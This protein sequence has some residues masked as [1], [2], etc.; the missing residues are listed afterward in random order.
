MERGPIKTK[1]EGK[2]IKATLP[3]S[4]DALFANSSDEEPSMSLVAALEEAEWFD[5]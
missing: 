4:L 3:S 1:L 2:T 5:F